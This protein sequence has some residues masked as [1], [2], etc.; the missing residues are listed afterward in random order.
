MSG[1]GQVPAKRA[2]PKAALLSCLC[3]AACSQPQ[4]AAVEPYFDAAFCDAQCVWD[5]EGRCGEARE[6]PVR[7]LISVPPQ[8]AERTEECDY[9]RNGV[10]QAAREQRRFAATVI[11]E[12]AGD[13][14]HRELHV[15]YLSFLQN[16]TLPVYKAPDEM[17]IEAG[18]D[19]Y[20][21]GRVRESG[22]GLFRPGDI[23]PLIACRAGS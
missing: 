17:Q 4:V 11:H 20:I 23:V 19:Y 3:L 16:P 7:L 6:M 8:R 15:S 21:A 2:W 1:G 5:G 18:A 12:Y 10:C 14:P 22:D 9:E 13:L